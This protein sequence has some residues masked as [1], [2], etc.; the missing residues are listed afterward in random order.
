[1]LPKLKSKLEH[2][3]KDPQHQSSHILKLKLIQEFLDTDHSDSLTPHAKATSRLDKE[4]AVTKKKEERLD[5]TLM[6]R[7][8]SKPLRLQREVSKRRREMRLSE[9]YD[10]GNRVT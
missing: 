2:Y 8:S 1:M 6:P 10:F 5:K 9:L 3:P 4:N 7:T